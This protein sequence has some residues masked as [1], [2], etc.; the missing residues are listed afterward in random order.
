[1]STFSHRNG[2]IKGDLK[3]E[4]VSDELKNSIFG[5][6]YAKEFIPN[7]FDITLIE[8]MLIHMGVDYEFP[9]VRLVKSQNVNRLKNY[10]MH[11]PWNIFFDFVE[12]Y[13]TLIDNEQKVE[14]IVKEFNK[15]FENDCSAYRIV[16]KIVVPITNESEIS[17]INSARNTKFDSVNIH[18]SKAIELYANRKIPDYEN[19]IKESI[20]AVESMCCIIANEK[21]TLGDALKKLESKGITIHHSLINA[22]NS[23]YG[24]TSDQGG[25]RH[26]SIEFKNASMEDAKFMLVSCSAFINYLMEKLSKKN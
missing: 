2:Y 22:F 10:V 1:M 18:I 24:F 6:F 25:I 13:L 23:L 3:L 4:Y 7:F 17:T 21:T 15:L 5:L 19:S 14:I 8:K 12:K 11:K 16:N 26:G 9:T 20:S